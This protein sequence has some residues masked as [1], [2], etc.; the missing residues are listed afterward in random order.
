MTYLLRGVSCIFFLLVMVLF[1][2]ALRAQTS[3]ISSLTDGGK[4]IN[5][6]TT[7][8]PFLRI[9]PDARAG[10]MG[11]VG[12]ASP[13]DGD[14]LYLNP[15]KM[16][17]I[18]KDYGFGMSFT[19]WLKALVNDIYLATLNGY[20]KVGNKAKTKNLQT[21]AMSVRYFSLGTIQF[22]DVNGNNLNQF[23]P[24]EFSVDFQYARKLGDYFSLA[25]A[26]RF[27]YSNLAA[28]QQVEGL[29][30]KAGIAGSG[31]IAW[32]FRKKYHENDEQKFVHEFSAGMYVS[33]IGS[34]ISYTSSTVKD[35]IPTNLGVGLG[36]TENIDKHNSLGIYS[37]FN[38]LLVP[39]P[40][41]AI[42]YSANPPVYKYREVSSIGGIFQSFTDAPGGWREELRQITI[43]GGAEYYYNKQFGLRAGYFYE[44]ITNGGRQYLTAGLTVKYSVATMSFSYL[45][46][47]TIQRNPLDNTLRFTL[48]FDFARG[49]NKNKVNNTGFSLVPDTPKQNVKK[50]KAINPQDNNATPAAPKQLNPQDP[51]QQQEDPAQQQQNQPQQTPQQQPDQTAPPK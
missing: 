25:A 48:L 1:T 20:Y 15:A 19:P 4:I 22:T 30:V 37:D 41:T 31:D 51:S 24:N 18:D 43:Q 16:A 14:G 42:D 6:V 38:K 2:P 33:N 44:P 32:Y 34:K 50:A 36:Y 10:G 9:D 7:A 5:T 11:D 39:T 27:I 17:F 47:T 21:L 12:I 28:G 8:V 45:I 23:R 3:T 29:P 40:D 49:G 13:T 35:F 26:L 46:P